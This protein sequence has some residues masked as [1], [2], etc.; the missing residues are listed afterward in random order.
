[1]KKYL[2]KVK[3]MEHCDSIISEILILTVAL[4]WSSNYMTGNSQNRD[5]RYNRIT[6]FTLFK[7]F[8]TTP[9]LN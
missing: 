1:M 9:I 4:F 3:I 6:M 2:N 8:F 7:Y 5:L